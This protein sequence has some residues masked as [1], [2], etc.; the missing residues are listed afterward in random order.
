MWKICGDGVG[1]YCVAHEAQGEDEK[2]REDPCQDLAENSLERGADVVNR[3]AG[4]HAV[5]SDLLISL[6][7]QSL[8]V[9]GCH[10]KE[11]CHPH[12]ED[13]AWSAKSD[14]GCRAGDIAGTNLGSDSSC[15]GLEGAHAVVSGVPFLTEQSAEHLLDAPLES[16]YLDKSC[17][18]AEPDTGGC[19]RNDQNDVGHVVLNGQ[20]DVV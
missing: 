8:G 7:H 9:N 19:Q 20:Y 18:D 15:Q 6:S 14:G 2:H 1:L 12:P 3:S 11:S 4:D 13:G 16:P 5:V 17:A 10:A